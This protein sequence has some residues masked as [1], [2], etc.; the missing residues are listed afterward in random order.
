MA[1]TRP[2]YRRRIASLTAEHGPDS[3]RVIA[4]DADGWTLRLLPT[5]RDVYLYGHIVLNCWQGTHVDERAL[6]EA[7]EQGKPMVADDP[8]IAY[9]YLIL[10]DPE[11]LPAGAAMHFAEPGRD[12]L[13]SFIIAE[14]T[15]A[16]ASP[17]ALRVQ[18]MSLEL[19]ERLRVMTQQLYPGREI[20][21]FGT[22]KGMDI[23]EPMAWDE[24]IARTIEH[25]E[26][27][28]ERA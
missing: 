27:I 2:Q 9:D 5:W 28:R 7:D 21:L 22:C 10:C 19:I 17:E 15:V 1:E 14:N 25:R 6:V 11:G 13:E 4:T 18:P 8:V 12:P 24:A 16:I 23:D 3:S 26:R 20:M